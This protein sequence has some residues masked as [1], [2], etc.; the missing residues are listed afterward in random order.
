M[1]SLPFIGI[2]IAW[3]WQRQW[4]KVKWPKRQKNVTVYYWHSGQGSSAFFH[5][6]EKKLLAFVRNEGA[7]P[8]H[9]CTMMSFIILI[10]HVPCYYSNV[11]SNERSKLEICFRKL[12]Q[13]K[14][15]YKAMLGFKPLNILP[16]TNGRSESFF[17]E[18]SASR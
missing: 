13:I 3:Y 9:I 7:I 15:E 11:V 5:F 17:L 10:L 8:N 12:H 6:Q 16:T 1:N 4:I 18:I 14:L 2:F